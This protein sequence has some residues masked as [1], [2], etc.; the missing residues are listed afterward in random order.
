[1]TLELDEEFLEDKVLLELREG[2][3][4]EGEEREE[5]LCCLTEGDEVERRDVVGEERLGCDE[6]ET[7]GLLDDGA[8]ELRLDRGD[9][10]AVERL[11]GVE[12]RD[13]L[14]RE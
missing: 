8:L 7:V 13:E 6:R 2:E 14:A 10:D 9:T 11:E 12:L 4:I 5:E 1:M 3:K